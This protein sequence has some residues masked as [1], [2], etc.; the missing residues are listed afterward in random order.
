M[1]VDRNEPN[2]E[3]VINGDNGSTVNGAIYAA[4]ARVKMLGG[5]TVSGGCTQ[6]VA[7]TILFSGNAG[8][9]VDCTG[10]GVR[11]IRSSRLVMLVE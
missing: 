11:D 5:S 9:G 7:R 8:I 3:H 6:V 1:F 2:N 4:S 10:S